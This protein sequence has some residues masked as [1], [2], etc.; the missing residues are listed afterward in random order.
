MLEVCSLVI[1][2]ISKGYSCWH[3]WVQWS[4]HTYIKSLQSLPLLGWLNFGC[5]YSGCNMGT[6]W[7][8]V[9][10]IADLHH[11]CRVCDVIP[12]ICCLIWNNE[13]IYIQSQ[14]CT[15]MPQLV[16]Q[17]SCDFI[18]LLYC[19]HNVQW[20]ICNS[21]T[22]LPINVPV[23]GFHFFLHKIIF[24]FTQTCEKNTHILH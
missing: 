2:Y 12:G 4:T 20:K 9:Q 5:Y 21:V 11:S 7:F 16:W 22:P 13:Q 15:Y 14:T 3:L 1:A 10:N 24:V 19:L 6:V 8:L 17:W 18:P 23:N